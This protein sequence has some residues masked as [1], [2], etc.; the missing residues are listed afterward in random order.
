M[1]DL[2]ATRVIRQR[3]EF[4]SLPIL[5]MTAN[6][7]E[8]DRQACASARVDTMVRTRGLDDPLTIQAATIDSLD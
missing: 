3:P 8:E 7:Y 2:A 6:A 5:A 4:R 1:D